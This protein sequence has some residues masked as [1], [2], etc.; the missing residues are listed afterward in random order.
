[1][2]PVARRFAALLLPA[3]AASG[4]AARA[5]TLAVPDLAGFPLKLDR[6]VL[7]RGKEATLGQPADMTLR[8]DG[9]ICVAD[10]GFQRI[11]CFQANGRLLFHSGRKGEGPGEFGFPYRIA[12]LPDNSLAVYD[13]ASQSLS[14][15]DSRGR[16]VRRWRLPFDFRQ[17][18][19]MIGLGGSLVAIAGY[20]PTAGRSADSAVHVFRFDSTLRHVR[21][22]APLPAAKD[23]EILEYWG[24]GHLSRLP[25]GRILYSQSIPYELFVYDASGRRHRRT[26]VP[27]RVASAPD[28]AFQITRDLSSFSIASTNALVMAPGAAVEVHPRLTLVQRFAMKLGQTEEIWWDALDPAT[29]AVLSSVRLPPGFRIVGLTEVL[30]T[31]RSLIG[32]A[33][34]DDEPVL[35]RLDFTL[36][37]AGRG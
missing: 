11:S 33:L 17:A 22:F 18:N 35:V 24:A 20:A 3:L 16:F 10:P 19:G 1:M 8:P 14:L 21:S 27:I 5:Q 30:P 36:R 31:G 15:L 23:R 9:S 28:L 12:S 7:F 2:S 37:P 4:T 29:G 34:V 6:A 32:M 25:G 26:G 13:V